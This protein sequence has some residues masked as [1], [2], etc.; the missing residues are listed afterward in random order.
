MHEIEII[1]SRSGGKQD[2]CEAIEFVKS[3]NWQ[4]IVSDLFP[5]EEV[6]EALKYLR[7]GKALGRIVLTHD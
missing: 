5:I 2:T 6:N 3:K 1:G 4:P 7:A